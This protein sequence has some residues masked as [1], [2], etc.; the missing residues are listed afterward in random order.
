MYLYLTLLEVALIA[1]GFFKSSL[2][3]NLGPGT[4]ACLERNSRRTD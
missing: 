2:P 3:I 1:L 4:H